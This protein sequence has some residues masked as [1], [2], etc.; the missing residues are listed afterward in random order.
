MASSQRSCVNHPDVFYCVYGEYTLKENRKTIT[1][2][3]KKLILE[4]LRQWNNGKIRSPK[5]GIPMV[6][7]EPINH[8]D[9]CYFCIVNI[10]SINRNNRSKW[11]YP[12]LAS[13]RWPVLHSDEIPIPT[14]HQLPEIPEDK[15]CN[16]DVSDADRVSDIDYEEA[17][18]LQRFNQ[19]ELSGLIR[20]L[21]LLKEASELLASRLNDKNLLNSGTKITFYRTR[22]KDLLSFFSH[23]NDLVFCNDINGLLLKMGLNE[24]FSIDWRLFIDSSKRSLKC[25]LLHNGSR[26]GSI[27]IAHTT[28]MKEE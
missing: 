17:S 21:C 20:E 8:F 24:Y 28:K 12:D 15:F 2:F 3:V 19:N 25:V 7:R 13:A 10:T 14:F 4:H 5:F 11:K 1:N 18:N 16:F 27:P 23:E 26:Y 9:N 22:E 6:W